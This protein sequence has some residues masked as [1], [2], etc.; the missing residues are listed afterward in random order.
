[1]GEVIK[2]KTRRCFNRE[3]IAELN[4]AQRAE[5]VNDEYSHWNMKDI[6]GNMSSVWGVYSKIH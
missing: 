4:V 5:E 1:M 2:A 3:G 6:D